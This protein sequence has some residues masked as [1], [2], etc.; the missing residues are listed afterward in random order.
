MQNHWTDRDIQA[1]KA[2]RK[3]TFL[4]GSYNKRFV[5]SLYSMALTQEPMTNNQ[6]VNLWRLVWRYRRQHE[7][8]RLIDLAVMALGF[9]ALI[10]WMRGP[11]EIP[12]AAFVERAPVSQAA[13]HR[14]DLEKLARWN[15]G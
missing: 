4:P 14:T 9:R 12:P 2:L 11:Q 7:E 6:L 13:R 3:C 8:Q 5:R 10:F 1:I 15:A